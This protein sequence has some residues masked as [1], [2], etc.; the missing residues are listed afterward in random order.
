MLAYPF[1]TDVA[2]VNR[3]SFSRLTYDL[4]PTDAVK[5]IYSSVA[6]RTTIVTWVGLPK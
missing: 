1:E 2:P 5:R 6:C 4:G 3:V